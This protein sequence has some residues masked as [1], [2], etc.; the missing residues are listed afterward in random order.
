MSWDSRRRKIESEGDKEILVSCKNCKEEAVLT[1]PK[2][3]DPQ[4]FLYYY[5]CP[6]CGL[7]HV[8]QEVK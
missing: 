2:H 4:D 8:L 7:D 6:H 1:V 3:A 5:L